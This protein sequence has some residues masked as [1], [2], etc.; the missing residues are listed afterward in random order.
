MRL[1]PSQEGTPRLRVVMGLVQEVMVVIVVVV[2]V[3]VVC[4]GRLSVGRLHARVQSRVGTPGR[5]RT[6]D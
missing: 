4:W 2:V 5:R 6:G 1:D 3:V